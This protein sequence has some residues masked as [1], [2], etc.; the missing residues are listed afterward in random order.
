M[1][2]DIILEGFRT[3]VNRL[4]LIFEF[5]L[6]ESTI[7]KIVKRICKAIWNLR[8]EYIPKPSAEKW[9]K[10]AETF[11]ERTN[12]PNCIGAVDGKHIRIKKPA[13]TGSQFYNYKYYFSIVLMAI[14]DA[15]YKFV[16]VD[17]GSYCS[18]SDS[19]IF[20][21]T[22]LCSAPEDEAFAI[23][24]NIMRPYPNQHLSVQKR[25]FNYR[26]C[27]SRRVV[28][29]TFGILVNKWRIFH[30]A[31][32]VQTDFCDE[33]VKTCCV[34]HNIVRES[35]DLNYEDAMYGSGMQSVPPIGTRGTNQG[36]SIREHFSEYFL[37]PQ[38]SIPWQYDKI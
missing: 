6:G 27:R 24:R 31:L 29:C 17:I 3:S 34:L 36:I 23:S 13:N 5:L 2:S 37:T 10:I 9:L 18:S 32:D 16:A 8:M 15:D 38:G 25:I 11:Q 12:F 30:R 1:E 35:E 21:S 28:E 20:K 22:K 19:N 4:G 26:L 14:A 33:I 7:R